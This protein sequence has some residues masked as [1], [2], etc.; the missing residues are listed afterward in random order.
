[1]RIKFAFVHSCC[2]DWFGPLEPF[3]LESERGLQGEKTMF[4][5]SNARIEV[6]V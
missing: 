2:C 6:A 3:V 1:M 5:T 4:L